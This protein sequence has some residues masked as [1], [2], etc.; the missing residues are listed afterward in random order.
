MLTE[1]DTCRKYVL[2]KLYHGFIVMRPLY[3]DILSNER[4]SGTFAALRH[5]LLPK[6]VSGEWRIQSA[7]RIAGRQA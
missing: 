4:E 6:L 1:A 7:K 2:P 5:V 3:E